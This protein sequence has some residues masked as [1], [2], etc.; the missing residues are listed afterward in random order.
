MYAR[1]LQPGLLQ[2]CPD[3]IHG[4]PDYFGLAIANLIERLE[5]SGRVFGQDA[6]NR[7][8]LNAEDMEGVAGRRSVCKAM[9]GQRKGRV[10]Q[11][12]ASGSLFHGCH[13]ALSG[14]ALRAQSVKHQ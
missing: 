12:V 1:R 10:S 7:V 8:K 9:S 5:R 6:P 3:R 14:L 11:E 2:I 13:Y 4:C